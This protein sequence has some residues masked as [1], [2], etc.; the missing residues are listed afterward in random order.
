MCT[1][2]TSLTGEIP[3]LEGVAS[4]D[5]DDVLRG[6]FDLLGVLFSR[7]TGVYPT[8]SYISYIQV[9]EEG[10]DNQENSMLLTNS[11]L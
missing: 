2:Q 8:V 5:L 10:P 1:F 4:C 9:I 6:A 11:N 3:D 7:C